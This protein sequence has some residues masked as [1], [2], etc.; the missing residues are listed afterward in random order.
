[1]DAKK[2]LEVQQKRMREIEKIDFEQK[3]KLD[4]EKAEK[5]KK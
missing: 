5:E 4:F 3:C 1:M 2:S